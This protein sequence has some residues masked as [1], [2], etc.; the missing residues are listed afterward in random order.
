MPETA[1]HSPLAETSV[2]PSPETQFDVLKQQFYKHLIA[3]NTI[4]RQEK[5][6]PVDDENWLDKLWRKDNKGNVLTWRDYYE[7][8]AWLLA[9]QKTKKFDLQTDSKLMGRYRLTPKQLSRAASIAAEA[10]GASSSETSKDN[11]SLPSAPEV[12]VAS[13]AKPAVSRT[14]DAESARPEQNKILVVDK[15][16][17]IDSFSGK[18]KVVK[19]GNLD[20]GILEPGGKIGVLSGGRGFIRIMTNQI[21]GDP[22]KEG[23]TAREVPELFV[24]KDGIAAVTDLRT[25]RLTINEGARLIIGEIGNTFGQNSADK[26]VV[27]P[28]GKLVIND[29]GFTEDEIKAL[30]NSNFIKGEQ[31]S[32]FRIWKNGQEMTFSQWQKS[33]QREQAESLATIPLSG[34]PEVAGSAG[35]NLPSAPSLPTPPPSSSVGMPGNDRRR[36][37]FRPVSGSVEMPVPARQAAQP[38][39][40]LQQPG[41]FWGRL[42]KAAFY[43]LGIGKEVYFERKYYGPIKLRV[44]RIRGI[45]IPESDLSAFDRR[46]SIPLGQ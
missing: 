40:R 16:K 12:P 41:N 24:A 13:S 1:S 2:A 29:G 10:L 43:L 18:A 17:R 5:D 37:D 19:D 22:I 28:D 35:R 30:L 25:G 11:V 7:R 39:A 32:I 3:V 21:K 20:V 46:Q 31:G 4:G 6:K 38:P 14:P 44:P 9:A 45:E 42:K 23:D 15:E 26:I 34:R 36:Y 27:K 33:I 8:K